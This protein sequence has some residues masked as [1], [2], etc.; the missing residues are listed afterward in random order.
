MDSAGCIVGLMDGSARMVSSSIS[1][2][3]WVRAIWPK[4]G[5]VNGW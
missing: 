1:G 5:F 3:P 2:Q 4:D